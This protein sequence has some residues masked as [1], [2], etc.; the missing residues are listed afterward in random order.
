MKL[1]SWE[2][3][4]EQI[5]QQEG[6]LIG[7]Q[8]IPDLNPLFTIA[9]VWQQHGTGTRANRCTH[10][11]TNTQTHAQ[12]RSVPHIHT[13]TRH[14]IRGNNEYAHLCLLNNNLLTN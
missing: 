8:D 6:L 2:I 10:T 7:E 1:D 5:Y 11:H 3:F 12:S 9:Q 4:Y 13:H 14:N